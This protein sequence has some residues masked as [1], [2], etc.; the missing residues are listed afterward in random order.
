MVSRIIRFQNPPAPVGTSAPNRGSTA[1]IMFVYIPPIDWPPATSFW[2][3]KKCSAP[4]G[5]VE[6]PYRPPPSLCGMP[7]REQ[8]VE[9]QPLLEHALTE[10]VAGTRPGC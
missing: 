10:R 6:S 4:A 5:R 2:G 7:E 9:Q 1:P 3:S 8:R